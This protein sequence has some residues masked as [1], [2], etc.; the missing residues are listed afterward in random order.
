MTVSAVTEAC[1]GSHVVS[2]VVELGG[3]VGSLESTLLRANSWPVGSSR[4]QQREPYDDGS[5]VISPAP[6]GCLEVV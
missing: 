1:P 6:S 4:A 3:K 5:Q 2:E